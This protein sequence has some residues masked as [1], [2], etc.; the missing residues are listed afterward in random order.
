MAL[1]ADQARQAGQLQTGIDLLSG[2]IAN[3]QTAL[4]AGSV[5]EWAAVRMG[6][7]TNVFQYE[8]PLAMNATDSATVINNLISVYQ[9][10]INSM[11][12]QL[13]AIGT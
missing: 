2:Y 8:T 13:A 4:A 5:I 6:D 1:T 11:Q 3:L 7:G 10:N 12:A 9:S